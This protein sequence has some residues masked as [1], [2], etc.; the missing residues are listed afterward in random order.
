MKKRNLRAI[1]VSTLEAVLLLFQSCPSCYN[2]KATAMP[3]LK[4]VIFVYLF[5]AFFRLG[6]KKWQNRLLT[7]HIFVLT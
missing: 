3:N 1:A 6:Y 4:A 5:P 2:I 7:L